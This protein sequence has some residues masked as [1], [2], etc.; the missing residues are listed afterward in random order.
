[1]CAV[2][3]LEALKWEGIGAILS[4]HSSDIQPGEMG[5]G[6]TD[7]RQLYMIFWSYIF[8]PKRYVFK[9]RPMHLFLVTVA[10]PKLGVQ[11]LQLIITM[12]LAQMYKEKDAT[13]FFT[14]SSMENHS[15]FVFIQSI[16]NGGN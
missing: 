8:A 14:E 11:I 4:Y 5:I 1:M 12:F 2:V 16:L 10:I 15:R 3:G 7:V 6:S 13:C 9:E